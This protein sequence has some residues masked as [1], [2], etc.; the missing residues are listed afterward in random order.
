MEIDPSLKGA[1]LQAQKNE[2]TEHEIYKRLSLSMP[3]EKN[4]DILKQISDDELKHY[5]FWKRFTNEDV[6]PD[7]GRVFFYVLVS[8]VLGL[9]FGLK[10]MEQGEDLTQTAYNRFKAIDPHVEEVVREEENHEERLLAMIDEE[11]LKY[12]GSMVL[13]LNDAIVELTGAL[14][15]FTLALGKTKLIAMAG[16]IIGVAASLSMAASEYLSTKEEKDGRH[17]LKASVYTGVAYILVVLLLTYPYFV[18]AS[19]FACLFTTIGLATLVILIFN[20]Y[21]SVAKGLSFKQRF[22]EM[23]S[24]SIGVATLNFFVGLL[25]KKFLGVDV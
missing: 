7:R 8:K 4:R 1:V 19:P 18:L 23:F 9:S 12:T 17:P 24:I 10:L 11:R 20:Y 13:G 14:A 5:R 6:K 16:I 15:G 2:I 21:I 3:D 22:V 25:A